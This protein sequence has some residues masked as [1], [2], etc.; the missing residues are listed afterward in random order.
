MLAWCF[1]ALPNTLLLRKK[2]TEAQKKINR[3]YMFFFYVHGTKRK[4]EHAPQIP[5]KVLLNMSAW[6]PNDEKM[7]S[8]RLR[9]AHT[10]VAFQRI[11]S[12]LRISVDGKVTQ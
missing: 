8:K 9:H 7:H 6:G 5:T 2:F 11:V 4:S 10:L 12:S 1:Q 3:V